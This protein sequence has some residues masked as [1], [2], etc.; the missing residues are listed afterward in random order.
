MFSSRFIFVSTLLLCGCGGENDDADQPLVLDIV[1]EQFNEEAINFGSVAARQERLDVC[2]LAVKQINDLGGILGKEL[3]LVG[4]VARSTAESTE[5]VQKLVDAD[6]QALEVQFSSRAI[7]A[8]DITVPEGRLLMASTAQSPSLT[9]IAD[10]DLIFRFQARTDTIAV[11]LAELAIMRGGSKAALI[12]NDDDSFGQRLS[13]QFADAFM[14]LGGEIVATISFPISKASGFDGEIAILAS[15]G[16]DVVLNN[17]LEVGIAANFYN[18]AVTIDFTRLVHLSGSIAGVEASFLDNLIEPM[19]I[20]GLEGIQSTRGLQ[21]DENVI[22]FQTSFLEFFG[23]LPG[24]FT[25]GV[26]DACQVVAL[27]IERAGRE[28]NTDNPDAEMIRD[29]FRAVLNP[30]GEVVGAASLQHALD[31]LRNNGE[32]DFN[33]TYARQWDENGDLIGRLVFDIS[34]LDGIKVEWVASAQ[35]TVFIESND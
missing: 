9:D 18:E 32:I 21:T 29:S 11:A 20:S 3:N 24:A 22:F 25:N 8:A 28:H 10:K 27:A 2:L 30:P 17:I 19:R 6:I 7:A 5:L 14:A 33:G 26:Y 1:A 13:E 12:F 23:A 4:F 31:I 34:T 16:A 35:L 15:S